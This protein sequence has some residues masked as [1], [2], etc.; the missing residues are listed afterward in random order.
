MAKSSGLCLVTLDS[1]VSELIKD[2][3]DEKLV[4][5]WMGRVGLTYSTDPA[6]RMTAVLGALDGLKQKRSRRVH[7]QS[8]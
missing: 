1:L 8:I 5:E 6:Q 3:P 7:E 4:K 2:R